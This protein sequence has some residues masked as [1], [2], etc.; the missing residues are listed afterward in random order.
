MSKN[1]ENTEQSL[2]RIFAI[3]DEIAETGEMIRTEKEAEEAARVFLGE[4]ATLSHEE[5]G[6][7]QL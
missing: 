6:K 3:C 4:S 5:G 2:A 7:E 1:T